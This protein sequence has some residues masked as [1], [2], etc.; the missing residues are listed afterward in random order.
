VAPV[1]DIKAVGNNKTFFFYPD[2]GY[3]VK[4]VKVDGVAVSP[5]NSYTFVNV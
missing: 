3:K 4:S 5:A 2:T 1:G